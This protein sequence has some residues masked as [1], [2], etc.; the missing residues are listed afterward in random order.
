MAYRRT[1]RTVEVPA[2]TIFACD[3]DKPV[4]EYTCNALLF[5]EICRLEI[6]V[7]KFKLVQFTPGQVESAQGFFFNKE[8]SSDMFMLICLPPAGEV[9][10]PFTRSATWHAKQ[11]FRDFL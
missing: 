6:F 7:I 8:I 3:G 2:G 9:M 1:T 10:D 4:S 5:I 11:P